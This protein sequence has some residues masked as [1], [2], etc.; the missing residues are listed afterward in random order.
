MVV[1][2][3]VRDYMGRGS[4][5]GPAASLRS[6]DFPGGWASTWPTDLKGRSRHP[7][8]EVPGEAPFSQGDPPSLPSPCHR[9]VGH[10]TPRRPGVSDTTVFERP[11][12]TGR[13]RPPPRRDDGGHRTSGGNVTSEI[14]WPRSGNPEIPRPLV[15]P[16]HPTQGGTAPLGSGPSTDEIPRQ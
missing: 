16:C 4:G 13:T 3:F 2:R 8:A 5:G 12:R 7:P 9:V 10:V 6:P 15:R 1:A 11:T 14:W